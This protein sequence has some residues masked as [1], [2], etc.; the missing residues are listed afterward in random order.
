[1]SGIALFFPLLSPFE[2]RGTTEGVRIRIS[3]SANVITLILD[4][5]FFIKYVKL[6]VC[7]CLRG[8]VLNS[9]PIFDNFLTFKLNCFSVFSL[10]MGRKKDKF[11]HG[12]G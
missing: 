11:K 12:V 5:V 7:L 4:L 3:F 10:I 2:E 8:K 6:C 1:M 9:R